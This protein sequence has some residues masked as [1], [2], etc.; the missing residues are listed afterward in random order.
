MSNPIVSVVIPAYKQAE[1]LGETIQSVLAQ[2]YPYF[3]I[4]VVNDAS[5]DH[6]GEVVAQFDDS[7]IR[8]IVHEQ[9]R[10]LPGARNTGMRASNGEVIALLDADDIFHPEKLR[11]HVEFLQAHPEVGVTYNGRFELNYSLTTIRELYRPPLTVDLSDFVVGYPFAPSDMVI[12]RTWAFEVD[13]FDEQYIHGG[14]DLD[15]PCRLALA[16][17]KFASVDRALNYRRHHSG[18]VRR[19]IPERL[20]DVFRSLKATFADPRCSPKVLE[21]HNVAYATNYVV[22]LWHALDQ[23]RTKLAHECAR[24]AIR[25]DPSLIT[26]QPARLV[27]SFASYSVTDESRDHELLLK[28][29][30]NQL[31]AE[32]QDLSSFYSWSVGWGYLIKAVRALIW[33]RVE[34]GITY[35]D[36][37]ASLNA[38]PDQQFL[39]QLAHEMLAYEQEFGSS[40]TQLVFNRLIPQLHKLGYHA[41]IRQFK[42]RYAMNRAFQNYR[43]GAY[44]EVSGSVLQAVVHYPRCLV[45]RG[46]LS[47]FLRSLLEQLPRGA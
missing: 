20:E 5:P 9:N 19:N 29:M 27:K 39:R 38:Q 10:G 15:F 46:V 34:D 14:E 8:Y 33:E 37:A 43:K 32:M 35:M 24:E 45:N 23:E 25:L 1:F 7:R 28:K 22:Y 47:I 21:L 11:T 16:G 17:C 36:R 2:T 40:R 41:S 30:F 26:A 44:K 18:R 3:E 6:T 13:L 42:G 31:P 4:I 12:R